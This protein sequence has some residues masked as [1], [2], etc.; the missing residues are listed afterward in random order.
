MTYDICRHID[1][2]HFEPNTSVDLFT[3]EVNL[4]SPSK[5]SGRLANPL[6]TSSVK[7]ATGISA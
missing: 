4:W 7:E 3:E 1:D 5:T 2:W 6:L